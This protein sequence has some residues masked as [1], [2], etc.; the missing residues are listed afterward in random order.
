MGM[1]DDAKDL[2]MEI[3]CKVGRLP[4]TYLGLPLGAS[5]KSVAAWDGIEERIQKILAMGKRL[6]ISKGGR[7]TLIRST[8]ASLPV[9]SMSL[10]PIPRV[11]RVRIARIQKAFLWGGGALESRPHLV[12]WEVA[13]WARKKEAWGLRMY[14]LLIKLF[15]AN[16]IGDLRLKE[17][18]FGISF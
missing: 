3:G 10:F 2:A 9:Y 13:C 11:V 8:L 1:D 7:T 4:S 15:Y 12:K 6:Y 14:P 16:G 17:T 18:L 5:Y